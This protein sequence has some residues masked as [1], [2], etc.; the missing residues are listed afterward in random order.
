MTWLLDHPTVTASVLVLTALVV[1]SVIRLAGLRQ[2]T[3]DTARERRASLVTWWFLV[4]GF[5]AAVALGSVGA[6][7]FMGLASWLAFA[8]YRTMVA[9]A[10]DDLAVRLVFA[11]IPLTYAAIFLG[12]GRQTLAFLPMATLILVA[13]AQ[14]ALGETQHYVRATGGLVYGA[15]FLNFGLAHAALLT[16]LP[17]SLSQP[18]GGVGWFF[19]LVVLTETNDISQA[20][21]GRR[22][23]KRPIT[24]KVSPHKTVEGFLG[25]ALITVTLAVA[26]A[27]LLSPLPSNPVPDWFPEPLSSWLWPL[28][29]G[30][31][32]VLTGFL[33]DLNMSAVKRDAGLKDS[34]NR[35]PGMGGVLDRIDSLSLTAPSFYYL[36]VVP[37]L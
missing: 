17:S 9:R 29:A 20:L 25:G 26:L 27:P 5:V 16:T 22:I 35:L 34:S 31:V 32:I 6:C 1:G 33:G 4:L 19:Y 30:M 21:V 11:T 12:A 36:I 3:E 8:E 10:T 24:P 7:L 18:A 23:G 14:I 2:V 13:A 28:L 15:V 37:G